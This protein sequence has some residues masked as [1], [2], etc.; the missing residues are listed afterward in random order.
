MTPL[1]I[2]G[3]VVAMASAP[4][5]DGCAVSVTRSGRNVWWL[6]MGDERAGTELENDPT[7]Q[8]VRPS[9]VFARAAARAVKKGASAP[10]G[11]LAKVELDVCGAWLT[12]ANTRAPRPILVRRAGWVELRGHPGEL[13]DDD[14][15]APRDDRI[16]LGPGDMLLLPSW[17]PTDE[18]EGPE[19]DPLFD[20]AL[21]AAGSDP[22][23][24]VASVSTP[25][26][27]GCCV[28]VGVPAELGAE[29]LER[30]AS[31]IGVAREDV[32]TPGYPL[33]D[34]QPDLWQRPPPPPR[35]AR[36]RLT[37]DRSNVRTVR[38]L[39]DRLLG[40]WRLDGRVDDGDLKLVATELSTNALVHTTA[41]DTIT[42]RYLGDRI[43]IEVRDASTS[44]PQPRSPSLQAE[45]GRGMRLVESLSKSWGV[46]PTSGG[47]QVWCEVPVAATS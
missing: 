40:S 44:A 39:L 28:A 46:D 1:S 6:L 34:L 42:I 19:P 26:Q 36:L 32:Q 18:L 37:S 4:T 20:A 13:P 22:L 24:L 16:G 5:P 30:V 8:T 29:P 35:A 15:A 2:P 27:P 21:R 45:G 23:D 33:G 43:R 3:M 9:E 47:K 17:Q 11:L 14:P 12:V 41:P 10:A 31:A 38:S 25:D 7:S